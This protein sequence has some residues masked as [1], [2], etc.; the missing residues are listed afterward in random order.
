MRRV[1]C[2]RAGF[3]LVSKPKDLYFACLTET[4]FMSSYIVLARKWRPSQF[5]HVV[6]QSHI[7]HTLTNAIRLD[8]LHQAYLFTGSSG[9][10]KTTIARIFAKVIRCPEQKTA[11]QNEELQ[12]CDQCSSCQE[13]AS[14]KGID[15]IEID[16]ASNNGVDAIREIRENAKFLPSSG[17]RKIYIIDEVHMLTTSAFNALLKTLEEPPAHVIFI[18]ATTEPHKIPATILARCQRFDFRRVTPAQILKR[19]EFVLEQENI[20]SEPGALDLIAH[21]AEGS[22]RDAL[23]LLDQVIAYSGKN[24]SQSS[25]REA[26]GLI[27][28]QTLNGILKAILERDAQSALNWIERAYTDGHDLRVLTQGLIENLHKVIL[29]KVGHDENIPTSLKELSPLRALEEMEMIFQALHYGIDW[30]ARSPRPKMLLDVL[31]IKC[32]R[33][34]TLISIKDTQLP[35]SH[36]QHAP[37]KPTEELPNTDLAPKASQNPQKTVTTT[38]SASVQAPTLE[39]EKNWLGFISHV[40]K[41]RPFLGSL[42]EHASDGRYSI[43]DSSLAINYH[44]DHSFKR[45]QIQAPANIKLLEE[46]AKQYFEKD[47]KVATFIRQDA[48]E[49]LAQKREKARIHQEDSIKQEVFDHPVIREAKSLFNAELGPIELK[50]DLSPQ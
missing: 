14:S 17:E 9:I 18:F 25:T 40:R 41:N 37:T 12:S 42:L 2:L 30:I 21:A 4:E 43:E 11:S 19:L 31:V 16:G 39:S 46:L 15:V 20:S 45:E 50:Q 27:E 32:A 1:G 23:S 3:F 13:I 49:S 35:N 29:A 6:G 34:Q 10:G 7:V 22:M 48:G 36:T 5:S 33:A 24:I 38:V 28:S 26:I 8:R 44:P 47:S